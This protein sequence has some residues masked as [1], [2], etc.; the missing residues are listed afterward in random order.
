MNLIQKGLVTFLLTTVSVVGGSSSV[1]SIA[2]AEPMTQ[3]GVTIPVVDKDFGGAFSSMD[4]VNGHVVMVEGHRRVVVHSAEQRVNKVEGFHPN[5][6]R[7]AETPNLGYVIDQAS[8]PGPNNS[9]TIYITSESDDKQLLSS[10]NFDGSKLAKVTEVNV[11][12]WWRITIG[13][14]N[15]FLTGRDG[16]A[17]FN[18]SLRL[19]GNY[20]R[21][22][23]EPFDEGQPIYSHAAFS[24]G[25]IF[26]PSWN[27]VHIVD[28][29]TMRALEIWDMVSTQE[30]IVDEEGRYL[31]ARSSSRTGGGLGTEY[32]VYD[33]KTRQ[34]KLSAWDGSTIPLFIEPT[35]HAILSDG[36]L[37]VPSGWAALNIWDIETHTQLM[38]VG[39]R[40]IGGVYP[41]EAV[42]VGNDLYVLDT[43]F[44]V[45]KTRYNEDPESGNG[46][47][48]TTPMIPSLGD[49]RQ[50]RQ[51]GP[52]W[53]I[54][55]GS[56]LYI[57]NPATD[58]ITS[59]TTF[60][61]GD[62]EGDNMSIVVN[63]EERG[64]NRTLLVGDESSL[65][66][67]VV[68][69]DGKL[70]R[71]DGSIR[72]LGDRFAP[73]SPGMLATVTTTGPTIISLTDT[74]GKRHSVVSPGESSEVGVDIASNG[75]WVYALTESFGDQRSTLYAYHVQD[76]S[77]RLIWSLVVGR[78][79]DIDVD[80]DLIWIA[81]GGIE[82]VRNLG[83]EAQRVDY[84]WQD[85]GYIDSVSARGG[86]AI[87]GAYMSLS[88]QM[89]RLVDDKLHR[90]STMRML[91]PVSGSYFI[92]DDSV[93]VAASEGGGAVIELKAA[94]SNL[95]LP[96]TAR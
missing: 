61:S 47:Y 52:Y 72:W 54:L 93:F 42:R 12:D 80:G 68:E 5:P 71:T 95:Y 2:H 17:K 43:Y 57:Y 6:P 41:S 19:I 16:V 90:S 67:F 8:E 55:G 87:A 22:R 27:G 20:T 51:V 45:R 91:G 70:V 48:D 58:R 82:V 69:P 28:A 31:A 26:I 73:V 34:L 77:L 39:H 46:Y 18:K 56:G 66:H 49:V 74:T 15:L 75:E 53:A 35:T 30:V 38:G 10:W 37:I 83:A 23:E 96:I 36:H 62:F 94:T 64:Q 14:D 44:G 63:P 33:M 78:S 4:V 85:R 65:S 59:Y 7:L 89:V 29:S 88:V 3:A 79:F 40:A 86:T 1:R 25:K 50:I 11:T 76:K 13:G 92:D 24:G 9:I 21:G 60:V 81:D 84:F 32:H